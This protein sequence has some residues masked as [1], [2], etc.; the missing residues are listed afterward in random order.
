[1][2]FWLM[3]VNK[4]SQAVKQLDKLQH[5]F[6]YLYKQPDAISL[7]DIIALSNDKKYFLPGGHYRI[8]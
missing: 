8:L 3:K 1:M 5:L 4:A 7:N 6:T 2:Y